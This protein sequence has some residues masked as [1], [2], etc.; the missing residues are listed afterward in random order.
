M[1]HGLSNAFIVDISGFQLVRD[2]HDANSIKA[3]MTSVS[4]EMPV[5]FIST[6]VSTLE[7]EA[8][9]EKIIEILDL[10][11]E[12]HRPWYLEVRTGLV[13]GKADGILDWIANTLAEGMKSQTH[14]RVSE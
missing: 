3:F 2:G 8:I 11:E 14:T 1:I 4:P 10:H 12:T 5:A 7:N 6:S 13:E 9:R